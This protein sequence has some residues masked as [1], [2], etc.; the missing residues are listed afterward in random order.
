[1][2][3]L[4]SRIL[5]QSGQYSWRIKL[6]FVFAFLKSMASKMP[7]GLAFIMII[8]FM[9]HSVTKQTCLY[10][11]GGILLSIILQVVFQNIEDRLQSAAGFMIFADKR[12]ELGNHLRKMP[13]GYFTEGNIGKISSVLS[14][15]MVFIEENCMTVI[16]DMMNY[17]FSECIM[18]AFLFFLHPLLGA[19]GIIIIM[20]YL[21]V[22]KGLKNEALVDSAERQEQ[23][24]KLTDAVL[25]FAEGIGIIKTY[26]LLGEKSKELSN[27]FKQMCHTSLHFE[28]AHA[29]WQRGANLVFGLS[30]AL[31]LG[32]SLLLYKTGMIKV[33]FVIGMIL[34]TFDI[35]APMKALYGNATRLTVMNSCLDRMEGI[36]NEEELQDQGQLHLP[37]NIETQYGKRL[38]VIQF[39][40]VDFAYG[41]KQVLYN[42]SFEV[43]QNSMIAL[44]G[45][46][47]G[48]K[49]TVANLLARFWDVSKG[50]VLV[51]GKNVKD[52]PLT[53]LMDHI[54]MVFQRVYLFQ[55]TIY[56][57]II[58]GRPDAT[59]AEVVEAA[60]K[61]R[62]YDFIMSLP[63]GFQT[64]VGEGGASLS[65]GECQRI[66]IARCILKDAPI[67]I[68]DEATASVDADN[69]SYIQEAISELCKGKTLLV[70]AH[71]LNTIQNADEILVISD[72]AIVQKGNHKKLIDEEGIYRN[73]VRMRQCSKG[74]NYQV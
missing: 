26:N 34:F 42:I 20:I 32:L 73:F 66:S 44:V 43:P 3:R 48:G 47:G 19:A 68:L 1:M 70:I 72:G 25:D 37:K 55:D 15:D 14:S 18:I 9:D 4:I 56:N 21:I 61:A 58:I 41:E 28:E 17:I 29:P 35:F 24:E 60:K 27:N 33:E 10:L 2:I 52:I 30:S 36:F 53:E 57:N 63:D 8:Q 59:E 39:K 46:S 45:A 22:G 51:C 62:C 12:M 65:G 13:M 71:R 69:E 7:M 16:G 50:E 67:V 5:K 6:A 40:N 31:L 23:S 74:W 49:S 54:S 64:V 38:P 11:A